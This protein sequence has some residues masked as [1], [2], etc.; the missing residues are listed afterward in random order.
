MNHLSKRNK[1]QSFTRTVIQSAFDN[2]KF[3][4]VDMPN[5]ALPGNIFE[6]Q[7]VEVLMDL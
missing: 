4:V 7:A 5:R 3:L 1:H 6:Q 2:I